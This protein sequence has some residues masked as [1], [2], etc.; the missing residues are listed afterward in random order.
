MFPRKTKMLEFGDKKIEVHDLTVAEVEEI[1]ELLEKQNQE[2]INKDGVAFLFKVV[3]K[4]ILKTATNLTDED[5][6]QMPEHVAAKVKDAIK[7]LNPFFSRAIEELVETA[8]AMQKK[9]LQTD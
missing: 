4:K 1:L 6:K 8:K 2:N 3:D 5:I 9:M 7:E